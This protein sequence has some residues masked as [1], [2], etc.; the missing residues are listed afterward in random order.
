MDVV[1][2]DHLPT[3]RVIVAVAQ[4]AEVRELATVVNASIGD[5]LRL[6]GVFTSQ[7]GESLPKIGIIDRVYFTK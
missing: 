5:R 2:E 1:R 4:A 7:I 3:Q 6:K